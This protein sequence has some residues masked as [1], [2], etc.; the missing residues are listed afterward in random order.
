[1]LGHFAP[2]K[3]AVLARTPRAASQT[4]EALKRVGGSP[5]AGWDKQDQAAYDRF[6]RLAGSMKKLYGR[7]STDAL[8]SDVVAVAFRPGD[9]GLVW[10]G[11]ADC[12]DLDCRERRTVETRPPRLAG[13]HDGDGLHAGRCAVRLR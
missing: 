6:A 13:Q 4:L 2:W 12:G 10:G 5:D 8:T 11:Q 1:V 3:S 9:T 7:A